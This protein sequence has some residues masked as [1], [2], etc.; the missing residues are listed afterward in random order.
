MTN[1]RRLSEFLRITAT[2]FFRIRYFLLNF[3]ISWEKKSVTQW[4]TEPLTVSYIDCF[5]SKVCIMGELM[6]VHVFC[7]Q[8]RNTTCWPNA[9]TPPLVSNSTGAIKT[10]PALQTTLTFTGESVVLAVMFFYACLLTGRNS[11]RIRCSIN[12]LKSDV[13]VVLRSWF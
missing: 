13:T 2:V 10:S 1:N 11:V 4:L 7:H 3:K 8:P 6:Q 12:I 5:W 9:A